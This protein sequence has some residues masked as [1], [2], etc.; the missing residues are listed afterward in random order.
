M[1]EDNNSGTP[2]YQQVY[3]AIRQSILSGEFKPQTRLPS[4]RNLAQKLGVSR[5]TIFNAYEQLY[6]EG[7][8]EGKVGAGTFVAAELP[9][10]LV[11]ISRPGPKKDPVSIKKPAVERFSPYG[12]R[13]AIIS[14]HLKNT[15]QTGNAAQPFASGLPAIDEFPFAI[16]GRI[17]AGIY[18]KPPVELFG[19]T[20]WQGYG[21]LREAVAA[22]LSSFRGVNC[23]PEQVIITAGAQ[24]A[25]DLIIRIFLSE[26]DGV[27]IENPCFHNAR[28]AFG[29]A[30]AKLIPVPVD[31]SG[32][33]ID[34]VPLPDRPI[35]LIHV[36]PSHQYPLGVTMSLPRR[37]ALLELAKKMNAWIIEDDYDSDFRYS[38]RPLA[39]L[40]GLDPVGRVIYVGTFSKTIFPSLRLGCVVVPPE[41][42]KI[43]KLAHIF[44]KVHCPLIDQIILAKFI[45][46]G[47][48]ERHI[49]RMRKL[50]EG[51]QK[52]FRSQCEKY[53]NGLIKIEKAD[54]GLHLVG[55]LPENISDK[56]VAERARAK[57]LTIAAVSDHYIG[58]TSRNGLIFGYT[59]FSEKQIEGG[60]KE[61]KKILK[62]AQSPL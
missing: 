25:L 52:Y 13:L 39:S 36:T 46:E 1:L 42:I 30:G 5:I 7:Y 15:D 62:F 35:K 19:Y 59:A 11:R 6:A 61:L 48:F 4:S 22:H 14:A 29:A 16:W 55:W 44:S 8:L 23:Q 18:S 43:F 9:N 40:Q 54:A 12:R 33:N 27:L 10:D 56:K 31:G 57:N 28:G 58:N 49:R 17:A 45:S 38:G 34:S 51:R 24:Q 2:L 53:L 37:F 32:L 47:H 41:L 50:Y 26:H 60:I 21:P 20:D 3:K